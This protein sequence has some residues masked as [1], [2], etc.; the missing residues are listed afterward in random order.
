[1]QPLQQQQNAGYDRAITVFSP[2][3][4]FSKLNMQEKLLKEVLLV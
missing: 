2:D 1:M 3:G 4:N